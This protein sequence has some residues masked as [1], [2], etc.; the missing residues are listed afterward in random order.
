MRAIGGREKGHEIDV[1]A[2]GKKVKEITP[3]Y[4]HR[5]AV[6]YLDRFGGTR[7]RVR[8]TLLK[9][10]QQSAEV[11]GPKE[12]AERWIEETLDTLETAGHINDGEFARFRIAKG[13]RRGKSRRLIEQDLRAT[14][15]ASDVRQAALKEAFLEGEV[16]DLAAAQTYVRKRGLGPYRSQPEDFEQKDL[17]RLARRGFSYEIARRALKI[18]D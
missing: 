6:W 2:P 9:R 11:H 10:V 14:G 1:T 8:Q 13:L 12:E 16:S 15:V 18:E 4:L 17:A 3:A 7:A 5:V